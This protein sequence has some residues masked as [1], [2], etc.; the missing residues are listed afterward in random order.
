MA[1]IE[2]CLLLNR[3]NRFCY[4]FDCAAN[5]ID[6]NSTDTSI[7]KQAPLHQIIFKRIY[8]NSIISSL[9]IVLCFT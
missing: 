6:S 7:D 3:Y 8:F 5:L 4:W 2:L 9:S 1:E